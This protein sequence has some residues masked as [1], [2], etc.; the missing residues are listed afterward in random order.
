ML[1]WKEFCAAAG[2]LLDEAMRHLEKE[3]LTVLQRLPSFLDAATDHDL[4]QRHIAEDGA[5]TRAQA[6][7]EGRRNHRSV[8]RTAAA[9]AGAAAR[10]AARRRSTLPPRAGL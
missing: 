8:A 6:V 7:D 1:K 3:E 9:Q 2:D 4:A 10:A 5:T